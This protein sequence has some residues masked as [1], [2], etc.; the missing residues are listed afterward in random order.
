MKQLQA[1]SD[2]S[3]LGTCIPE[4]GSDNRAA[5]G[6][7]VGVSLKTKIVLILV[8]MVL[9]HMAI[10]Y[11][12]Q[13]FVLMP[14]FINLE[15]KGA[16]DDMYRCLRAID[17]EVRHL[18]TLCVDWAAWDDTYKFVADGNK[19]YITSNLKPSTF[20]EDKL[21]VLYICDTAGRVVW[22]EV[23]DIK[24]DEA[25]IMDLREFPAAA[26]P[27]DHVLLSTGSGVG[28][29]GV[30]LTQR[31]PM[32]VA[33][34][35]IVTSESKGP[36]RGTLVMGRLLDQRFVEA[37]G[38]QTQ[39]PFGLMTISDGSFDEEAPGIPACRDPNTPCC[40]IQ[41]HSEDV[42]R[43]YAVLWD[44]QG[45][46]GLLIQADIPRGIS[47]IGRDSAWIATITSMAAAV[48]LTF[49][50]VVLLQKTV[51]KPVAELTSH[52]T[53]IDKSEDLTLR[54]DSK[55][56][57]EIGTLGREFDRMVERLHC[58]LEYRRKLLDAAVT[59]IFTV[60]TEQRITTVNDAFEE[61]TGLSRQDVIGKHCSVLE[62]TPCLE[63]CG[64]FDPNRRIPIRKK[65]CL[66]HAKDGRELTILKSAELLRDADGNITGGVESFVDV[67]PMVNARTAAEAQNRQLAEV[68]IQFEKEIAGRK[69]VEAQLLEY[70]KKLQA[71]ASELVMAEDRERQRLAA[72]LHD[73][74]TQNLV[75]SQIKLSLLQKLGA[76][77]A[78]QAIIDEVRDLIAR[79][80][81]DTRLLTFELCPPML[82]EL[83]IVAAIDWLVEEFEDHNDIECESSDDGLPKPLKDE[84]RGLLFATVRELLRN[85]A[86]HSSARHVDVTVVRQ[87]HEVRVTVEDDGVGF[88]ASEAVRLDAKSGGFGL[89]GIRERLRYLGGRLRV[90]SALGEGARL[91]AIVPISTD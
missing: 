22:G 29:S 91:T 49:A 43:G 11:G 45:K 6:K 52:V 78:Q 90:D 24:S 8:F 3:N 59:G 56:S 81:E 72:G 53:G 37:L 15:R 71:L 16:C 80:E 23:R 19:E 21:N 48:A 73:N 7:S 75:G 55:R 14:S 68:N 51:L 46:P 9:I 77:S 44:I 4:G 63:Q 47:A 82:Y 1:K 61:V 40:T 41:A 25:E 60:D 30:Y 86:R 38:H 13:R 88:D 87:N 69:H 28:V 17:S 54:L 57:D 36:A 50:L 32:L 20:V 76:T 26:L 62:G 58:L 35:S 39:V 33:A 74:V 65:Q 67:T 10:D 34:R 64:L 84:V 85:V 12:I 2:Q 70:Q 66:F 89:F 18:E 31:G 79:T 42:L 27:P 83:G 5:A